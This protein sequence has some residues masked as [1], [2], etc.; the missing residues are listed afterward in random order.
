MSKG[1]DKFTLYTMFITKVCITLEDKETSF[2]E[3]CRSKFT[4]RTFEIAYK[5]VRESKTN[6]EKK[7]LIG[8]I[9][10]VYFRFRAL[11][12]N[13]S[14]YGNRCRSNSSTRII[15]AILFE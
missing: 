14:K 6:G 15:D 9:N 2:D 11:S 10:R 3:V 1:F 12:N 5:H 8:G 7:R 4:Y 13:G